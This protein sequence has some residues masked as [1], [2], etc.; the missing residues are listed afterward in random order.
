MF[1]MIAQDRSAFS[2]HD[3]EM[4]AAEE[5]YDRRRQAEWE[6]DQKRTVFKI[7]SEN[8]EVFQAEIV[9]LSK[10]AVKL[11]LG[12]ITPVVAEKVQEQRSY[13]RADGQRVKYMAEF[14]MVHLDAPVVK[15]GDWKFI[16]TL[17]HSN[18]VGN[19]VRNVPNCGVEVPARFRTAKPTCEHC[20]LARY[21]HDTFL[22]CDDA[23]TIRQIGRNCL[24]DFFGTDPKAMARMAEFLAT[25][26]EIGGAAEEEGFGGGG[27]RRYMILDFLAHA[28]YACRA[29]GFVSRTK[30]R[31]EGGQATSDEIDANYHRKPKDPKNPRWFPETED[32]EL[33]EK[34]LEWGQSLRDRTTIDSD[35]LHNLAVI[36]WNSVVGE[37]EYGLVAS[38]VEAYKRELAREE[39]KRQIAENRPKINID[40]MSGIHALFDKAQENSKRA[41]KVRLIVM[42]EGETDAAKGKEIVLVRS[43]PQS[44]YAG[45]INVKS[46]G[47]FETADWYGRILKD[48]KFVASNSRVAPAGTAELLARFAADPAGVAA[49]YGRITKSCSYCDKELSDPRALEVGYGEICAKRWGVY[50]PPKP[51]KPRGKK[52]E[53]AAS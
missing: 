47:S 23:G 27:R 35:Y 8:F 14:F 51:K 42:P 7:P 38:M 26:G 10:R 9:K 16:A 24:K 40:D 33:A 48:G 3:A 4:T 46:S 17:D 18:E 28:A 5:E 30:A 37:R 21:R 43:G 50:F 32:H 1:D 12:A 53:P 11:G 31:T 19:I 13:V 44:Q 41:P 52:A 36:S 2:A 15:L 6:A 29:F 22:F 45:A 39:R 25:A 49:E 20:N 34:V